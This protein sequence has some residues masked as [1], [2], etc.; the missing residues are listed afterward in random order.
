MAVSRPSAISPPQMPMAIPM[1]E[2][3]TSRSGWSIRLVVCFAT[4]IAGSVGRAA[5]RWEAGDPW[6]EMNQSRDGSSVSRGD[7]KRRKTRPRR[8]CPEHS[9]A[10]KRISQKD[11]FRV[12]WNGCGKIGPPGTV[13]GE[14]RSSARREWLRAGADAALLPT[15]AFPGHSSAGFGL[16]AR[17]GWMPIW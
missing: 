15:G 5:H 17:A 6:T 16:P 4:F 7:I 12:S 13:Q 8:T 14:R 10:F 9:F 2:R 11:R 1:K 3:K